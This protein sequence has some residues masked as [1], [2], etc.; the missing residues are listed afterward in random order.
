MRWNIGWAFACI[1]LLAGCNQT[2]PGGVQ[3]KEAA[4]ADG[5][6]ASSLSLP[7]GELNLN[8]LLAYAGA[9]RDF[10]PVDNFQKSPDQSALVGRSF[11]V[12][13]PYDLASRYDADKEEASIFLASDCITAD[14]EL[15]DGVTIFEKSVEGEKSTAHNGFGAQVEVTPVAERKVALVAGIPDRPLG[16]FS[17]YSALQKTLKMKPDEARRKLAGAKIVYEGEIGRK[18]EFDSKP[19][20]CGEHTSS[21]RYDRPQETLTQYCEIGVQL[22]RVAIISPGGGTLVEWKAKGL[23]SQ[24]R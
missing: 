18:N 9:I 15:H 23:H 24:R 4:D 10:K 19:I 14:C 22:D 1:G 11:V 7:A 17:E 2:N 16:V 5:Y 8:D 13:Q 20:A 3:N 21:A 12:E 6:P